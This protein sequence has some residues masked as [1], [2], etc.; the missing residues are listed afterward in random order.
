MI[1][2]N[3]KLYDLKARS[4]AAGL[5]CTDPSKTVQSDAEDADI[6]TIV[7]RF[8][9][10]GTMPQGLKVP[11]YGDYDLVS[12]FHSALIAVEEARV[13]FMAMPANVRAEFGNDPGSFL[14]FASDPAN[15]DALRD[16][17]LAKPKP[18][19]IITLE[20]VPHKE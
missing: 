3:E 13:N 8:G 4:D 9:L 19:D 10:T 11:E 2:G 6:N 7:R 5:L 14:H 1:D 18:V 12:D 16:L 15:I 17:G 20:D